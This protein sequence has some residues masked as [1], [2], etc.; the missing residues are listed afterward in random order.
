M[1]KYAVLAFA[2]S[3]VFAACFGNHFSR[4]VSPHAT[5]LLSLK[6]EKIKTKKQ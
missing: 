5:S 6:T 1:N 4:D 3:L 2:F